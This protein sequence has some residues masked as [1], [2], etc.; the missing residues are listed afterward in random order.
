MFY[1]SYFIVEK[2]IKLYF[3]RFFLK[4]DIID[5]LTYNTCGGSIMK[6][7]FWL[8]LMTFLLV[9]CETTVYA[10]TFDTLGGSSVNEQLI[11][12]NNTVIEPR[13]PVKEGFTFLYWYQSDENTPYNFQTQVKS[14]FT[15]YAKWEIKAP[16]YAYTYALDMKNYET[17]LS[18]D[19]DLLFPSY[20]KRQIEI[21]IELL[22]PN[23]KLENI[24]MSFRIVFDSNITEDVLVDVHD[25]TFTTDHSYTFLIDYSMFSDFRSIEV[26][27]ISGTLYTNTSHDIDWDHSNQV[28]SDLEM[29]LSVFSETSE[30]TIKSFVTV[31]SYDDTIVFD[32]TTITYRETPFYLSN[33]TSNT[34]VVIYENEDIYHTLEIGVFENVKYYRMIDQQQGFDE[35]FIIDSKVIETEDDFLYAY[36]D[37][38]YLL[39]VDPQT[40]LNNNY[41]E[42][43]AEQLI[44]ELTDDDIEV[45]IKII[46]QIV[47]LTTKIYTRTGYVQV[48]TRYIYEPINDIN[49]NTYTYMPPNNINFIDRIT[50]ASEL[51][52]NQLFVYDT[53]NY[54]AVELESSLYAFDYDDFR[55]DFMFY[56]MSGNRVTFEKSNHPLYKD[57]N[58]IYEVTEGC[59]ILAVS[60]TS[61]II[62]FYEFQLFPL[63]DYETLIDM[64]A[65]IEISGSNFN[66][67]IEGTYDYVLASIDRPQGG[68]MTLVPDHW[69]PIEIYYYDQN[70]SPQKIYYYESNG[71]IRVALFPGITKLLFSYQSATKVSYEIDIFGESFNESISMTQSYASNYIV[72]PYNQSALIPFALTISNYI[73]IYIELHPSFTIPSA[74]Y[75]VQIWQDNAYGHPEILTSFSLKSESQNMYLEAGNYYVK[76]LSGYAYK[77]KYGYETP[78]NLGTET[79]EILETDDLNNKIRNTSESDF[80]KF[81]HHPKTEKLLTF[82]LTE[83][84][85]IYARSYF[86]PTFK[87]VDDQGHILNLYNQQE[88]IIELK[89]GTYSMVF[90]YNDGYFAKTIYA[91][92]LKVTDPV[93]QEDLH[94]MDNIE[95]LSLGNSYDVTY[96]FF[97]DSDYIMFEVL[98]VNDISISS[99]LP[100]YFEVYTTHGEFK[101]SF[102]T[103]HTLT[104]V[105]PGQYV[106]KVEY[107]MDRSFNI[108]L[109]HSILILQA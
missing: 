59:Y 66:L 4:I 37:G 12:E 32:T 41:D 96:D 98:E 33:I 36:E 52:S 67:E 69:A 50:D 64:D 101:A 3:F 30:F 97:K 63:N 90:E 103:S 19:F 17:Y 26:T 74:G 44:S 102:S 20:D 77:I 48:T 45:S 88:I 81:S 109:S 73:S 23:A 61:S 104:N 5:I 18:Y 35:D 107:D 65:P 54:Y 21:T 93:V 58:N 16:T 92:V 79:I 62:D 89:A 106:L 84:S 71:I 15:L 40:F 85:F 105:N 2:I 87:L 27:T 1:S 80:Q 83:T 34:G 100:V 72:N 86:L 70:D 46:D 91:Y 78:E 9:G 39:T 11:E 31:N 57:R 51:I 108:G 29:K 13:N 75:S 99:N 28:K 43:L 68:M 47:V 10:V 42:D 24:T 94:T 8:I 14:D 82:S 56:D 25:E 7:I 38:I 55:Y 76:L 95:S 60:S 49:L 53:T 22:E 6:K